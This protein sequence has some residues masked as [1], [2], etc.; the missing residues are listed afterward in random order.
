MGQGL[1]DRAH[2]I[3]TRTRMSAPGIASAVLESSFTILPW[4]LSGSSVHILTVQM[5]S[6]KAVISQYSAS[7]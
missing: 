4:W 6:N 2:S 5:L 7:F 3:R 1:R